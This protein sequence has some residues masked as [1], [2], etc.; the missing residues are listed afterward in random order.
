MVYQWMMPATSVAE[1]DALIAE[2]KDAS[3]A[4]ACVAVA[5]EGFD[6]GL[7][8]VDSPW[9]GAAVSDSLYAYVYNASA[10][11][12][13][14]AGN[15]WGTQAS[16][17]DGIEW[18]VSGADNLY[19]LDGPIS[20]G[21]A[22]HFFTGT[23]TDGAAT[24]VTVKAV[25]KNLYT[26]QV[27][28]MYVAYDGTNI[29]ANVAEVSEACYWQ[30]VTKAERQA[31]YAGA[32]VLNPASATFEIS[33]ANF[34]RN[35][36]RNSAWTG[37]PAVGGE[38]DN[39]CA[40]KWNAGIVTVSQ[41]L[42]GMPNGVYR[43]SAQGFY[44]MGGMAEAAAARTN[45]T[46]VL[47]AKFF[48]NGDS[49]DVMSVL[50]CAGMLEGVGNAGYTGF[51][52]A[53]N[54]MG[55]ASKFFSAGLYE[56]SFMF[57]LEEGVDTIALGVT[58][59]GSVAADW[60]I[61][62]NFRLEF[63][64][65][66]NDVDYLGNGTLTSVSE[67]NHYVFYTDAEGKTHFLHAAGT[68][69]WALTESPTTMAFTP[70]NTSAGDAFAGAAS[71]MVSNGFLMSNAAN[72][73]GSGAIKTEAIDGGNGLAAGRTWESQVFY[74]NA[75][76]KHAIRLTNS[77]GESWGA[78]CFVNIDP[79]TFAVASGQ[80]SLGDALYLWEIASEDDPRFSGEAL[81]G[82]IA[83]A[84]ALEGKCSAAAA[85][86]L[87]AAIA[88]AKEAT[89][90]QV[91]EAKTALEAAI[92]DYKASAAQYAIL[93][94]VIKRATAMQ[95][96][97]A[98]CNDDLA[99][100]VSAAEDLYTQGTVA[101]TTATVLQGAMNAYVAALDAYSVDNLT[102]GDFTNGTSGWTGDMGT[103]NHNKWLNVNNQFVEKWTPA[104]GTLADTDFCQEIV[105]LPA[106]TYTFAAYVS[107]CQQAN[108]D[109]YEVSGVSLYAN[110]E[111]TAVHT[112]NIDR[113]DVNKGLGAEFV[114]VTVTIAEGETL[115]VGLKVASTDANWVVMDN[116]KL[117]NFDNPC[118]KTYDVVLEDVKVT[119]WAVETVI[120][121]EEM[122]E[123][124]ELLGAPASELTFQLVDTTGVHANY[125]G[126]PGEVLFWVDLEGN[127][128]AWGV[129]NKFFLSY[130]SV[131]QTIT[132]TQYAVAEGDVLNATVRLA[133]AEGDYV[134]I[135]LTESIFVSPIINIADFE[136]V[137]TITVKHVEPTGVI[138]SAATASFD[139]IST[140]S[141]LGVA[142]LD[143]A[144]QYILNVTTGNL[145]AN[146]T[147][148]WRDAH[149]DAAN[150]GAEG[151]VCVKIQQPS[152]GSIDYIGC[153]D[154]THQ[155]GEVYTAKWAFVHEG[156]AVVI[157][158][159]IIFE[160]AGIDNIEALENAVIYTITGKRVQG[161]VKS[162]ESG[163]YIVNGKKVLVK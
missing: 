146:T 83:E 61:F 93:A 58:K 134:V 131:A 22:S 119:D 123:I 121:A 52:L 99:A 64:G 111:S 69:N 82:L 21:G 116:A 161:N 158:V 1:L 88:V 30:F 160:T 54:S 44:R 148:G 94:E 155:H 14:G 77:V 85:E 84:E 60:L 50:D 41:V 59:T 109:S 28:G 124:V 33:G 92:A 74:K 127:A 163:I 147:D 106:G 51:D 162:L 117:Y 150:W 71:F 156:K 87:A 142:S 24:Q 45:G 143:E 115:K 125:N 135:K 110:E 159:V 26:L 136:V 151:G 27:G 157:E 96:A 100:A 86:A 49:I 56:H 4:Y 47:H 66:K 75:A 154:T 6:F 90:A 8:T 12:F 129:N 103:G 62:D 78:N 67:G 9:V 133:N 130:D 15:S 63:L 152:S 35:D 43:L 34:G 10:K 91:Q 139:P 97:D 132:S 140:A 137:S 29:V 11:A 145:V 39:H 55:E 126:N 13:L 20:N 101:D 105:G 149:G 16:F 73:D 104:P 19:T 107:A 95:I 128:S 68:N 72:S 40:E 53:P 25:G 108:D 102:N 120:S 42:R 65:Q 98:P 144:E 89:A 36:G 32:S 79:A 141:A 7:P 118:K 3:I 76:G 38:N 31:K 138:Y 23:Y 114:T 17:N 122:A 113:N 57:T 70:G 80:P 2:L 153:I 18:I 37:S 112:I 5:N 46:E 81:K 48:A